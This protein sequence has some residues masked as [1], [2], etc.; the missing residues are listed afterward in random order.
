MHIEH[1]ES[2]I[3]FICVPKILLKNLQSSITNAT[4]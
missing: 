1:L 3:V 4:M 2:D